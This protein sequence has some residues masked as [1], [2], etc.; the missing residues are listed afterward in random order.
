M[1]MNSRHINIMKLLDRYKQNKKF[2]K[3]IVAFFLILYL[4]FFT[5]L[6]ISLYWYSK[7]IFLTI[8]LSVA[9]I[10]FS[11]IIFLVLYKKLFN[12]S[13]KMTYKIPFEKIYVEPHP[14]LPYVYKKNF[15]TS[16]NN[17]IANYPL[18]Q[19]K[20]TFETLSSNSL[21][22]FNSIDGSR[23]IENPKPKDLLR[24]NCLGAS[25]TGNYLWENGVPFSYPMELEKELKKRFPEKTVE[26]NNCGN[27]GWT[28]KEILIKFLI[29]TIDTQPDIIILYHAY[30][31]IRAYITEG[32]ERDYSHIRK[33]LGETLYLY[34]IA[35]LIPY[36]P[37]KG[38]NF[39]INQV[40]SQNSRNSL[41]DS[42]SKGEINIKKDFEGLHVYERNIQHII[43]IC[44]ANGIKVILSTYCHFLY[45]DIRT[46]DLHIKYHEG[47]ILENNVIQKLATLHNIPIVDNSKLIPLEEKY[48]V[49]SVHFT[50]EGMQFLA[51]NFADV[52][53]KMI[54]D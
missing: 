44:K 13:Y 47:V 2:F 8:V 41:I 12:S 18:H 39:L 50:P 17:T 35:S 34:R 43:N 28:S 29:D 9:G 5:M 49:D 25:T 40:L 14:Y 51:H 46:S 48:F 15:K 24:V 3:K 19:G 42:V 11:E 21:R 30:N 54:E 16:D 45:E 26:V 6:P 4:F 10:L 36:I 37:L 23:E 38:F 33:N 32:F 53:T 1:K 27:G 20:Y 52:V 31:D 22:H 7:S